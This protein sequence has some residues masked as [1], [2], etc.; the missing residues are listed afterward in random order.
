[1]LLST[2]LFAISKK[3]ADRSQRFN[4]GSFIVIDLIV[5]RFNF[6]FKITEMNCSIFPQHF[7]IYYLKFIRVCFGFLKIT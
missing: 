2:T 7:N 4:V 6:W 3:N 5:V 1:M